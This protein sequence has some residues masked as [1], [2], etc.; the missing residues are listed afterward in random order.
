MEKKK[1]RYGIIGIGK[2]GS[3]HSKKLKVGLIK[4]SALGAVCD[5]D[6]KRLEWA[7][8]SLKDIKAFSYYKEMIDSGLVDAVLISTPHY[9]HPIIAKYSIGKGIHTIIEKP[10]GVFTKDIR[11]LNDFAKK[12][13][14][15]AFGIM[16]NQRTNK[17]YRKAKEIMDSGE[18]G[19]LKRINW[20]ITDWYRPQAYY[21]Q[22]GWRG[23]WSGEGGGVLINQCPHQLDLFQW[24]VGMPKSIRGYAKEAVIRDINVE[25]DVTAY[26][27]FDN[28]ASGLF[29]TSTHDSPGTNRLEISSDGGKLVIENNKLE[30][31]K[32]EQ[33]ES[34]FSSVNKKF[35]PK[36]PNK[37]K[38]VRISK[39][40]ALLELVF[41]QHT[42][43]IKNFSQHLLTGEALIAPGEEGINGLTISN[44]IHLSSWL[45]KKIDLPLDEEK[46]IEELEKKKKTDKEQIVLEY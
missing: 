6:P 38:T 34:E 30:Y 31:W 29:V 11:E 27:E 41:G 3:I 39:I 22:G 2:M 19:D 32:L 35:M 42:K 16:Y 20:L 17:L 40:G 37:K 33:K 28:N 13:P 9:L 24:L 4:N 14:D 44:A 21:D 10:A 5:I 15:V 18:M 23:T 12:H 46:F 43:I 8:N 36:I 1:I 7:N 45:D 26:M 25:N